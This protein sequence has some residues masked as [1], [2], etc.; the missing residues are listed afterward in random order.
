MKKTIDKNKILYPIY[1]VL[2]AAFEY[3]WC[4]IYFNYLSEHGRMLYAHEVTADTLWRLETEH[5]FVLIP[6]LLV[7]FACLLVYHKGFFKEFGFN[8]GK[9]NTKYVTYALGG[10]YLVLLV[11]SVIFGQI[12][13]IYAVDQWVYFLFVAALA[14]D[15]LFRGVMPKML[16][17]CGHPE[18][19]SWVLP[20][21]LFGV[22]YTLI[23]AY[24]NG[25]YHGITAE[26]L[27]TMG[28]NIGCHFLFYWMHKKSHSIW[29]PVFAHALID[30]IFI[31]V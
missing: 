31:L 14:Q 7:F 24:E 15:I 8:M 26:L 9:G 12:G 27:T 3:I 16:K 23:H 28:F 19:V 2:L 20:G 22:V 18:W 25:H 1:V 13:D 17:R 29:Q 10:I 5:L 21:I 4:V 30:Y 6:T 11:L